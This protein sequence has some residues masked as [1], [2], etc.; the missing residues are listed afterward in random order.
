MAAH[1]H[2]RAVP[3]RVLI[4]ED[5]RSLAEFTA[6]GLRENGF[7]VD[8]AFDGVE[9]A[10]LA[11]SESYDV[12]I[13]DILLPGKSGLEVLREIRGK[14]A[15]VPVICVTARDKVQDRVLGLDLGADDYL[16]K[17]FQFSE[18]LARLRALQRRSPRMAP[19]QLRVAD[20]VLDPAARAVTRAGKPIVL[21]QKEFSLLEY[22]MRRAGDVVTRTAIIENVWDMN[23]D[24]LTNVVDV[25]INR[26]RLK[27][28][29]PFGKPLIHTVRGAGYRIHDEGQ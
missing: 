7:A 19:V 18:L 13:L 9:G 3:L 14:G 29:K 17:P 22:L 10:H 20:L 25:L 24:S 8:V 6:R 26:L 4:V 11:L 28:D 5:D 2:E 21:T 27:I 16:V 1:N 23:Y 12:V 15:G